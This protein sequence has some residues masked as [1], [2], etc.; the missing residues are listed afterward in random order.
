MV[1]SASCTAIGLTIAL[2]DLHRDLDGPGAGRSGARRRRRRRG[3]TWGRRSRGLEH[4]AVAARVR[5]VTLAIAFIYYFAPD[6]E[7]EWV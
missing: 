3:S 6:A 2:A 4:R 7:Q 5:L 1:E